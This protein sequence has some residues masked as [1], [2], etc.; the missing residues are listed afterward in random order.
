[1]AI[2]FQ[3]A[4]LTED[5]NKIT[6]VEKLLRDTLWRN[7]K[8]MASVLE[9]ENNEMNE[10][11]MGIILC[12]LKR[13]IDYYRTKSNYSNLDVNEGIHY[14]DRNEVQLAMHLGQAIPN[15][16]Q[17]EVLCKTK[18]KLYILSLGKTGL[19]ISHN[20]LIRESIIIKHCY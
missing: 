9:G 2:G 6:T 15:W 20:L 12:T 7:K 8:Q 4:I 10:N 18:I 13:N 1:M 11:I 3:D 17:V 19:A 5:N 14:C 16:L